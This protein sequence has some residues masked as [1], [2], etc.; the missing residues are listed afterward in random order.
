M[1]GQEEDSGLTSGLPF[2]VVDG[3]ASDIIPNL[4]RST[5]GSGRV[6]RRKENAQRCHR[7]VRL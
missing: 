3:R 7:R 2:E 5:H 6:K 4:P 1:Q